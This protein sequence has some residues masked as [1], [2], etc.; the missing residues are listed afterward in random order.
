MRLKYLI[1]EE[2][3][4]LFK[5]GIVF[6]YVIVTAIYLCLLA[7]IPGTAR[8]LTTVI[9]VFT[10]PAAM[11]C[12]NQDLGI[13]DREDIADYGDWH[14]GQRC[15]L[16]FFRK[17]KCFSGIARCCIGIDVTFIVRSAHWLSDSDT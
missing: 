10:D 11:G 17:W 14:G 3:Q 16:S 15:P 2:F 6:L 13:Y 8:E 12:T 9:L 7:A 5:Y 4:L 1:C